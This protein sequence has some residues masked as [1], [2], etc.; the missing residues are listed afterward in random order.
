[1][2]N[3]TPGKQET[4]WSDE[5][6]RFRPRG[7]GMVQL[8]DFAE[9]E[10]L[11]CELH[12]STDQLTIA[13]LTSGFVGGAG[14][15]DV[16]TKLTS[17]SLALVPGVD[18]AKISLI[19]N[20]CFRSIPATSELTA[21]LDRAQQVAGQGPCLDAINGHKAIRCDDLRTDV[22]WPRFAPSAT[23]AG[24]HSVLSCPMD[25]RCNTG[26]TLSLFGFQAEAFGVESE[27]TSAMLANHAA[28]ALIS[29]KQERQFRAALATRDVIGQAKGMVMERF[30]VDAPRAFAMLKAISQATNTPVRDLSAK[31]VDCA[32]H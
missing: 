2:R 27:A 17:A 19:D 8:S 13:E 22:R 14:I 29:A 24:V 21:L 28:I 12:G 7:L 6:T 25:I 26:A 16:L 18:L 11:H 15:V 3:S 4:F 1:V 20:G 23:A 32:R 31:L 5:R 30:G 9:T 10:Q